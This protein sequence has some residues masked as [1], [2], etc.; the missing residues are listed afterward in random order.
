[1]FLSVATDVQNLGIFSKSL[2]KITL[3]PA[4]SKWEH[5]GWRCLFITVS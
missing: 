2:K 3:R 4:H 1:M 5:R